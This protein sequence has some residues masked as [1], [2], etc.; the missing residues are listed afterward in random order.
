MIKLRKSSYLTLLFTF[1]SPVQHLP[2]QGFTPRETKA[3]AMLEAFLKKDFKTAAVDFN[4]TLRKALPNDKAEQIWEQIRKRFGPLKTFDRFRTRSEGRLILIRCKFEKVTL[5]LRV[6][7]D[8]KN[9]IA[10]F[11]FGPAESDF[12]YKAPDYVQ[13]DSFTEEKVTVGK[14][15]WD[16]PATLS[17]PKGKGP[18]PAVVLVHCSGPHDQ[19]E[20]VGSS[21][22]FRDLAWGLASR[23]IAVLRYEKRTHAYGAKMVM[24]KEPITLDNEVVEDAQL[25]AELLT[26]HSAVDAKRIYVL[27]HSLGAMAAPKIALNNKNV[28][29][30]ILLA[31]NSRPLQELIAEQFRYLYSLDGSLSDEDREK[32][33]ALED[34]I[35]FLESKDLKE[36][37]PG[38]KLPLGQ[39]GGYWL[40]LLNYDQTKTAQKLSQPMLI[41][42]GER[43]YQVTMEDFALWK[44]S[45]KDKSNVQFKSYPKLNHLLQAGEGKSTPSEYLKVGHVDKAVIEDVARWIQ[46]GKIT[47]K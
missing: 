35:A 17:V 16:L 15:P 20:T 45:L 12:K 28:A 41:L 40:S 33:K 32:L 3:K 47:K 29:G 36:S 18:F 46:T 27:G 5:D 44:K 11:G 7:F 6:S 30:V 24:S 8:E 34:K 23:K 1:L 14:A 19:D 43:D 10:G 42:Q 4:D 22:T 13:N 2:A 9:K 26:K 37:T 21:K 25:A 39:S 31:G 38:S